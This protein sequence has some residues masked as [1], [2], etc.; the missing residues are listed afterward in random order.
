MN[1]YIVISYINNYFKYSFLMSISNQRK[2]IHFL[3][4]KNSFQRLNCHF[5][6]FSMFNCIGTGTVSYP[7]ECNFVLGTFPARN[8]WYLQY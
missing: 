4:N 5:S 1:V 8:A 3:C 6:V 2:K 7:V